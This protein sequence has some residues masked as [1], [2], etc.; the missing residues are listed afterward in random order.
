[1]RLE[2]YFNQ[3][4]IL[5]SIIRVH[6]RN[7]VDPLMELVIEF[8]STSIPIQATVLSLVEAMSRALEGEFKNGNLDG[9][10]DAPAGEPGQ[11]RESSGVGS[12]GDAAASAG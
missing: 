11:A 8:W 2:V 5:V 9:L 6:I 3:L 7:Y 4:S 12:G 1:M 10:D